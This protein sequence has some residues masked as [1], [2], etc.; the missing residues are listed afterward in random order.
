LPKPLNL[1]HKTGHVKKARPQHRSLQ[2]SLFQPARACDTN[3]PA[4]GIPGLSGW[5][6]SRLFLLTTP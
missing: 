4:L 3:V 2:P 1:A 6:S 5:E